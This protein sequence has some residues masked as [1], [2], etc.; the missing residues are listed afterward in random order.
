MKNTT[1]RG[2]CYGPRWITPSKI[3]PNSVIA[4]LFIQNI[5]KLLEEKM[6]S[7]FLR[8][9]QITQLRSQVFPVISSI[10]CNRLLF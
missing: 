4:S 3:K 10:M 1:D 2:G 8:S 7:L 6:N 5:F 9:P